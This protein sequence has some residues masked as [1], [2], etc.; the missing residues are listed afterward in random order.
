MYASLFVAISDLDS[1]SNI[2][3]QKGY[4]CDKP[5]KNALKRISLTTESYIGGFSVTRAKKVE[6]WNSTTWTVRFCAF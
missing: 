1:P 2:E 3:Y 4:R 5:L 6:S